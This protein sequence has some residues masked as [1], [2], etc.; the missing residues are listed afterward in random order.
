MNTLKQSLNYYS[1]KEW[2]INFI[3]ISICAFLF[4]S[5]IVPV[6]IHD[7]L[8]YAFASTLTIYSTFYS[9]SKNKMP[10]K[11]RLIGAMFGGAFVWQLIEASGKLFAN[12][13]VGIF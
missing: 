6:L 11:N 2:I 5:K 4:F 1:K 3:G 13:A 12:W 9:E 8:L 7:F 10:I